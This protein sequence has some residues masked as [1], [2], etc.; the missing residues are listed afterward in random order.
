MEQPTNSEILR[1][2]EAID[3]KFVPLIADL[4]SRVKVNE[5]YITDQIAVAKYVEQNGTRAQKAS[6]P[7]PVSTDDSAKPDTLAKTIG[8]MFALFT[9]IIALIT[10][11]L[12]IVLDK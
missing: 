11:I 8:K 5:R 9:V 12:Q 4:H 7:Q 2:V 10:Y 6:T 1:A 3:R